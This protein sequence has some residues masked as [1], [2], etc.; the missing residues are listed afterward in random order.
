MVK[1]IL[2]EEEKARLR[3]VG[4]DPANVRSH[5]DFESASRIQEKIDDQIGNIKH[6][7]EMNDEKL[8]SLN[9]NAKEYW[10]KLKKIKL[11]EEDKK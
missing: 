2:N 11:D 10:E 8:N 1:V 9:P 6:A 7:K 3:K 5:M 4:L